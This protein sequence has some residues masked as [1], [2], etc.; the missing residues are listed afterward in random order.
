[1]MTGSSFADDIDGL[2][3]NDTLD[4][5]AGDDHLYGG[6]GNDTLDGGSGTD[7]LW[8]GSGADRFV[9]KA[10]NGTDWIEDFQGSGSAPDVIALSTAM[11]G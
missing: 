7:H 4:G 6:A 3:G 8:G 2:G 11:F 1:T 9:F 5:L 10:G